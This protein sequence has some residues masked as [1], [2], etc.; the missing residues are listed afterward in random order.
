MEQLKRSDV[1]P[2]GKGRPGVDAK[3]RARVLSLCSQGKPIRAI[4]Q[5]VGLASGT[6]HK[7]IKEAS[8]ESRVLYV[9][10]DREMPATVIDACPL[11]KKV[12]IV[13]LTDKLLSRAFGIREKPC[14]EDYLEFLESRCMPRT[15]YGIREELHYLGV[16]SYDPF[17]I[18]EKTRGRVYGDGQW[19]KR[20][21]KRWADQYDQVVKKAKS[22][23]ELKEGLLRL[24]EK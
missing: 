4:G 21:G 12:E 8:R 5:E 9:F 2:R 13:N 10:M 15:Q 18:V 22:K 1:Q 17:Q 23:E 16:D 3:T 14:W 19:L 11:T 24:L 7:I 6:V 20:M